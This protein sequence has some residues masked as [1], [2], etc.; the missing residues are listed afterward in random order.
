MGDRRAGCGEAAERGGGAGE[1]I[2]AGCEDRGLRCVFQPETVC[3]ADSD[4]TFDPHY[5]WAYSGGMVP[6]SPNLVPLPSRQAVTVALVRFLLWCKEGWVKAAQCRPLPQ[7][8][9]MPPLRASWATREGSTVQE[10][11]GLV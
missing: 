9:A 7:G 2:Y 4:A 6:I 8:S 1:W 10:A 5:R 3:E 11:V